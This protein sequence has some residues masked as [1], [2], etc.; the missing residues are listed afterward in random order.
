MFDRLFEH[1]NSI[2]EMKDEP[3]IT[4]TKVIDDD[5]GIWAGDEFEFSLHSLYDEY[6]SNKE[7][8]KR[9]ANELR[10]IA[11]MIERESDEN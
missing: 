2:N 4:I 9:L 5:T 1:I 6:K 11:D 7:A 10:T 3:I 8:A